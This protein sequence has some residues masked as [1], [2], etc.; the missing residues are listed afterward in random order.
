M[1]LVDQVDLIQMEGGSAGKVDLE[2][3]VS[4]MEEGHYIEIGARGAMVRIE[5]RET[6]K[7]DGGSSNV[8]MVE[9]VVMMV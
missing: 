9:K 8:S 5:M 2:N 1:L 3:L 7:V 6:F 4:L